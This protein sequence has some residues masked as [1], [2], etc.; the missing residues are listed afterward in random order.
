MNLFVFV[1]I[2]F[3]LNV[4]VVVLF[5]VIVCI[6]LECLFSL[7]EFKVCQ[8]LLLELVSQVVVS[9]DVI[10]VIFDGDDLCL[11]V[12]VGFCLIYDFCFVFEYVECFVV[13][14]DEFDGQLFLVMCVYVE[15]L[16]IMVGWKGF[17][18]DLYLD[19]SDDMVVGL[20]L[21]W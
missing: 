6:V 17:V 11:L 14:S 1:L 15:K 19:G 13:L 8:L 2:I 16:C 5:S 21:F 7:F 3:L 12:V 18:Y 20:V 10:C 9:C 4:Q